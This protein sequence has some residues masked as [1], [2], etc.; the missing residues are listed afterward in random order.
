M[1]RDQL[2]RKLAVILHADVVGSTSLV[3]K[4]ETLAHERIQD[5]FRRCAQTISYHDGIA[6]EIRGDALVAEFARA[7]DA[8]S[9][10][11]AFQ[12]TNAS[13]NEQLSDDLK[14]VLRIGIA[15]GEVV[16]ADNT[17]TGEGVV[18]AQRL[19][20]LAEQG[21][22]CIQGAV[23]DTLPKRLPF[24]YENLGE[25][26]LK[27]F[28]DPVRV[29]AVSLKT[30]NVIPDPRPKIP[31]EISM[32]D[33]P[34]K[35][36]IAVLPFTNMSGDPE[37][38]FFSDGITEDVTTALSHF[39]G[40]FVI[41]RNSSFTY[42]GHAVDTRKV[43]SELGVRYVLE[44]SVRRSG[45]RI[46]INGQLID[47]ET[48]NHIWA[49]RFDG[50]LDDIFELQDEITRKIVGSIAPQIELAEVERGR[51]L[52]PSSLSSYE[53]SLKAK[54]LA[55]D[56]FRLG[57]ADKLQNAIDTANNALKYDPRNTQALWLLGICQ[58]DQYLYQWGHDPAGALSR[59][60][61]T[62][63]RLIHVDSSN[64]AGH[65]LRGTLRIHKREFD[66]AIPDFERSLSLNPNA[67][68]HLFFAAW[69]ESLAGLTKLAKEHAE[70]GI[71][72]SPREM[73]IWMGVA[74]LALLQASFAEEN[75]EDA[76]K[77]GRLAI[78]MHAKAPIRQALMVACCAYMGN[79]EE[80]AKHADELSVFSPD[81]IP[82][83]LRGE[84]LLYRNEEHNKLLLEGLRKAGLYE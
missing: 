79:L 50:D 51:G 56:A 33:I 69:G 64:A 27:G 71:R 73:D 8:V 29:Y 54:S 10:S 25:Q 46:R 75:F 67:S 37:Q 81:F 83:I 20:Q 11:L 47:A 76:I 3:Q 80:A 9:A 74:Y 16:I 14:P 42:K 78:Q 1:E 65:S 45:N 70:L 7:S 30:G 22:I 55:Y 39:S 36:S 44:G 19:E 66:L 52:Q 82:T 60:M 28:D 35:P 53:L 49:E 48:A 26:Q 6:H 15:M 18:L 23:Y 34:E 17:V 57:D 4:H 41:A 38:E 24:E 59:A 68:L 40:L 31:S 2:S 13:Y 77:W 62:V 32:S 63:E 5:I 12:A 61:H 58:L 72:L 21:G 84:L 43:S